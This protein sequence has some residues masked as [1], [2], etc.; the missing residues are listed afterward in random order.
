MNRNIE[1][2]VN[3]VSMLRQAWIQSEQKRDEMSESLR[4]IIEFRGAG[5]E[6]LSPVV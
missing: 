1:I 2:Q 4:S 3:E 6:V 5:H